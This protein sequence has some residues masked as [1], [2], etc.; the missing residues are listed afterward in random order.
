MRP[1]KVAAVCPEIG[2]RTSFGR[3]S[4][5]PSLMR[6]VTGEFV[7][8]T[9]GLANI[10]LQSGFVLVCATKGRN[11]VWLESSRDS[12][13]RLAEPDLASDVSAI[14]D[15]PTNAQD[16]RAEMLQTVRYG[17]LVACL[18]STL[19]LIRSPDESDTLK[20]YAAAA[21]RDAGDNTA[22]LRLA[23]IATGLETVSNSLLGIICGAIYPSVINA[24]TLIRLLR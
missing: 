2:D 12:L 19:A 16:V 3:Y 10:W 22:R 15:D 24:E 8:T 1:S 4:S 5:D 9:E 23:E 13:S 6:Q 14:I 18:P 20:T 21:I 7:F 11:R 17:N